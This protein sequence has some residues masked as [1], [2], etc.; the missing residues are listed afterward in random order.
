[1]DLRISYL[2]NTDLISL[3][4]FIYDKGVEL[5]NIWYRETILEPIPL[6]W[7]ILV[8]DRTVHS[9]KSDLPWLI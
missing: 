1:M 2:N 5:F 9:P 8:S 3:K 4:K 6:V 7:S